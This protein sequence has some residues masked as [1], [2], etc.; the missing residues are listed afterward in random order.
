MIFS[1]KAESK[2]IPLYWHSYIAYYTE[3]RPVI[4]NIGV[5]VNAKT[6]SGI[7]EIN[8]LRIFFWQVFKH[9]WR[10]YIA[11]CQHHARVAVREMRHLHGGTTTP[12]MVK[13][14]VDGRQDRA[15]SVFLLKLCWVKNKKNGVWWVTAAGSKNYTTCF[16]PHKKKTRYLLQCVL[17][18][19]RSAFFPDSAQSTQTF[20]ELFTLLAH[21]SAGRGVGEARCLCLWLTR[22]LHAPGKSIQPCIH[23]QYLH[24]GHLWLVNVPSHLT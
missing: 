3:S 7:K 24:A 11:S 19:L 14:S 23:E 2:S 5:N 9:S 15:F 12:Y 8:E 22:T 18:Q 21:A 20:T 6:L 1:G 10:L 16:T 13:R 4:V 17:L